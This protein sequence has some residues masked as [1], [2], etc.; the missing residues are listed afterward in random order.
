LK[1]RAVKNDSVFNNGIFL[2]KICTVFETRNA[3]NYER[4]QRRGNEE[5]VG[6]S[7]VEGLL[8]RNPACAKGE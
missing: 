1:N 6:R 7:S 8:T 5:I 3:G 2:L 4:M